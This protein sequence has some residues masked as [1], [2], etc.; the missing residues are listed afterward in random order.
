MKRAILLGLM[1][2]LLCSFVSAGISTDIELTS[3]GEGLVMEQGDEVRF[4]LLDAEHAIYITDVS[5]SAIKFRIAPF[6]DNSTETSPAYV[7]LDTVSKIDLDRDNVVDLILA[8]Y[9]V[10]EDEARATV[11]FQ[12]VTENNQATGEIGVVDEIE[13]KSN[14][15]IVIGVVVLILV[16]ILVFRNMGGEK[17]KK[18]EEKKDN[19]E[20]KETEEEE[21]KEIVEE[22]NK[23]E[24]AIEEN[25]EEQAESEDKVKED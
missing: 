17:G 12:L 11:I 15:L 2:I 19:S 7:S 13:D 23:E 1:V 24:K 8:L 4:E 5:S 16:L 25:K 9:S 21:K 6:V 22:E 3:K 10:D 14:Y 20:E 18:E